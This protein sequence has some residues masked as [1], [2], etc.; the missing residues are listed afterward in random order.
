MDSVIKDLNQLDYLAVIGREVKDLLDGVDFERL[1]WE[2][3]RNVWKS[4]HN[5]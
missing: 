1:R 4:L 5:R 3:T 2:E